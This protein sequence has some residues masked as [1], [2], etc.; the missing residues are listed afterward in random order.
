M[1]KI[2]LINPVVREEDNPKHIPYGLSLMAAIAMAEN[3]EVQFYDANAWRQGYDI[4]KEICLADDWDVIG[5]GG[6]TTAYGAIKK[7]VKICKENSPRSFIIAGGGFLTSMPLEMMSWLPEID[8]GI[9]G[10]AFV[11]WPE[12]LKKIDSDDFDF[13]NTLGVC[14]RDENHTP[15][16]NPVRPNIRDLDSLPYPAWDLLPMDIYFK[17]S[18]LVFSEEVFTSKRRIDINGSIGCSLICKYCWHLG[19]S[20]EMVIDK[21]EDGKNDVRFTYGRI[22]RHHSPRY[23]VDMIKHLVNKYDIDFCSFI[24][25]NL[26]TMDVF[27]HRKWLFELC[28]LWIKEG[29]QPSCRKKGIKHDETCTGVHWSGTSHAGLA[30]RDTLD[31]MYQAGC[32]HLVYGIESFDP[33]ILKKIGK[34]ANQRA[35]VRGIQQCLESGIAPLPNIIIGFPEETFSSIRI[36]LEWML[37]LGIHAKPHFATPYPGS[38]WYYTYKDSIIEQYNGNLESFVEDLGDASKITAVISEKFSGMQLLGLQQIIEKRDIR[39]LDQAERHWA[40][41]DQLIQPVAKPQ[42]SFHI[43]PKK[44]E[45]PVYP[46]DQATAEIPLRKVL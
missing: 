15:V 45:A 36:T 8:L 44:V 39:L 41:A 14:Y 43:I 40:N 3:H 20:G 10:E 25:E 35:N 34:G 46:L 28:D 31:A 13:K 37:K 6:L 11:T 30:R 19:T 17:N 42:E 23:I 27:S 1:A 21:N 7:T 29:F 5:I 12:I 32:S 22:I 24:D 33:L 2:L 9:V 16:L 38:E 4:I 26:M 18:Q